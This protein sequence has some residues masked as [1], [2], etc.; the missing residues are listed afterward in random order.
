MNNFKTIA[1]LCVFLILSYLVQAQDIHFSQIRFSPLNLNPGMTGAENSLAAHANYRNQWNSVASPFSTMGASFESRFKDKRVASKGFLA[2]GVNFFNDVAG[3]VRMT[4]TNVNANIAYHAFLNRKSTL[5][6]GIQAGFGQRGLRAQ[7]GLWESQFDGEQF[8][9]LTPSGENF[10]ELNF[11]HFDA[12]AG[13]VYRYS[14]SE[15]FLRGNDNFS[16]TGGLAAFHVNRPR[17]HFLVNGDNDLAVR[18]TA[19][20]HATIGIPNTNFSF[21][22]G[23]YYFLQGPHQ[24]MLFGTYFRTVVINPSNVTGFIQELAIS[25]GAFYRVN[26]A[27]VN[28]LMIEFGTYSLG[29]SY[30]FNVSSLTQASRGRGGME[31]FLRYFIPNNHVLKRSRIN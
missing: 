26:D 2:A 22:P 7:D 24:E 31:F 1:A 10:A 20:A 9:P 11:M 13:M 25:Y 23:A 6:L 17:N 3:D 21:M 27:F 30:D 14:N 29:F 4:T 28:K 12:S 19:F 5:G 18:W 8:N 15:G 16:F